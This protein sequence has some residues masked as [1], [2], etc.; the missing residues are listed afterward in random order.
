MIEAKRLLR[1]SPYTLCEHGSVQSQESSLVTI[2][3]NGQHH[4]GRWHRGISAIGVLSISGG[5]RSCLNDRRH[6]QPS[7]KV[8][9]AGGQRLE[10]V[11]QGCRTAGSQRDLHG[12]NS[13]RK[14]I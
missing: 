10:R 6:G 12:I 7:C 5:G 13:G 11:G 3:L 14:G 2:V 8:G 1:G 9:S 4:E